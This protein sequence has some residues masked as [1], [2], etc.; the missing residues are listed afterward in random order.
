MT[1]YRLLQAH[2]HV[3]YKPRIDWCRPQNRQNV[4]A[5]LDLV[6]LY[7][8]EASLSLWLL[9]TN[10]NKS[11]AVTTSLG[12]TKFTRNCDFVVNK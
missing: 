2:V 11:I 1:Y 6:Y 7:M 12:D 9:D 5:N 8:L 10:D 4:C 3:R